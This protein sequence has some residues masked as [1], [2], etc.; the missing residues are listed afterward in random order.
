MP[1]QIVFRVKNKHS[2]LCKKYIEMCKRKFYDLKYKKVKQRVKLLYTRKIRV[3]E[4]VTSS[5]FL[6]PAKLP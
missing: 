4:E 2:E 3:A 1:I 5:A 6:L